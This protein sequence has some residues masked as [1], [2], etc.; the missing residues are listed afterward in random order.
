M[1]RSK[2]ERSTY[3]TVWS[4]GAS[5]LHACKVHLEFKNEYLPFPLLSE[6][7]GKQDLPIDSK[8]YSLHRKIP[9]ECI[10]RNFSTWKTGLE[11]FWHVNGLPNG[12]RSVLAIMLKLACKRSDLILFVERNSIH[13]I[14]LRDGGFW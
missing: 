2:R 8:S 9:T 5:E 12:V 7:A 14:F 4:N 1:N 6:I 13:G 3:I 11:Y 10:F